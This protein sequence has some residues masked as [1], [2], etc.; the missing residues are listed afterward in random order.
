MIFLKKDIIYKILA[1]I[2]SIFSLWGIKLSISQSMELKKLQEE[3]KSEKSFDIEINEN[4]I[5]A[6]NNEI[7]A[8]ETLKARFTG[9][10]KQ[11]CLLLI[12]GNV[13]NTGE[14]I[15]KNIKVRCSFY[16]R[17]GRL[18]FEEESFAV[19]SMYDPPLMPGEKALFQVSCNESFEK[20]IAR[21]EVE[22]IEAT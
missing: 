17:S 13:E 18:L 7:D 16:S 5:I 8:K 4:S 19:F 12:R 21:K 22:I 10:T 3:L 15:F 6:E 20:E 14:N 1:V 2:V 11:G 9:T